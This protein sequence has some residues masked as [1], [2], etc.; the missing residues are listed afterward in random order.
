MTCR[1]ENQMYKGLEEALLTFDFQLY[2]SLVMEYVSKMDQDIQS[3]QPFKVIK[4]DEKKGMAM[5]KEL[6]NKLLVLG[7]M[8]QPIM[9]GTAEIIIQSILDNTKPEN[10]F[11]RKE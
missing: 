7:K 9:P 5:I 3:T 4:E 8:L 1:A 11:V 6:V 10:L 2:T